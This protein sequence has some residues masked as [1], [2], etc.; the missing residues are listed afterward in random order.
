MIPFHNSPICLRLTGLNHLVLV[1]GDIQLK[2]VLHRS[3]GGK[4]GWMDE[5]AVNIRDVKKSWSSLTG[6]SYRIFAAGIQYHIILPR[7]DCN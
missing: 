7:H 5:N 4:N 3:G 6:Y 2:T 1:V